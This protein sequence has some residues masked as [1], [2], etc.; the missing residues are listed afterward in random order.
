MQVVGISECYIQSI[1]FFRYL[2]KHAWFSSSPSHR[3][4]VFC[5][6]SLE[7]RKLKFVH[8]MLFALKL[9]T[10]PPLT[11]FDA[12]PIVNEI[13]IIIWSQLLCSTHCLQS[14]VFCLRG[15]GTELFAILL[16]SLSVMTRLEVHRLQWFVVRHHGQ[17][18]LNVRADLLS[19]NK[20]QNSAVPGKSGTSIMQQITTH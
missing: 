14:T 15:I 12:G 1:L 19:H 20:S 8:I 10:R 5:L 18:W 16:A 11:A 6:L 13:L 2:L 7:Y 9:W 3:P 17:R 4:R